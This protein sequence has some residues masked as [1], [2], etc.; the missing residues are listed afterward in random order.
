MKKP[1]SGGFFV[2]GSCPGGVADRLAASSHHDRIGE[3]VERQLASM[4]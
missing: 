1:P 3:A 4:E 2:R